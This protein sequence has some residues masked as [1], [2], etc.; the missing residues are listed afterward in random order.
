MKKFGFYYKN[1]KDHEMI[2]KAYFQ[3]LDEA[4]VGFAAIKK[5]SIDNFLKIYKVVLIYD[6]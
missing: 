5:L 6:K 1:G 3:D 2:K 4:V